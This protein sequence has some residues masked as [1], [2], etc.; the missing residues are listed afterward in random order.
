MKRVWP[1]KLRGEC[2]TPG[3]IYHISIAPNSVGVQ[4]DMP[5]L[6]SLNERQAEKLENNI[7]DALEEILSDFFVDNQP[8]TR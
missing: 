1:Y 3:A 7:H 2:L 5:M 4:V 6:L 8:N